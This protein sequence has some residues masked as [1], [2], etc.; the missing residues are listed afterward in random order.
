[1]AWRAGPWRSTHFFQMGRRRHAATI[2]PGHRRVGQGGRGKTR[3]WNDGRLPKE[4]EKAPHLNSLAAAGAPAGAVANMEE[5][6][7]LKEMELG[8]VRKHVCLMLRL[9]LADLKLIEDSFFWNASQFRNVPMVH[10]FGLVVRWFAEDEA[11]WHRL[12]SSEKNCRVM[13]YV[14]VLYVTMKQIMVHTGDPTPNDVLHTLGKF[15]MEM[16]TV[17]VNT[18]EMEFLMLKMH[19]QWILM[20]I[21]I[22]M[23]T[24]LATTLTK[25]MTE[26][27][28]LT[29]MKRDVVLTV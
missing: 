28:G 14:L 6:G 15:G 2:M 21:Q 8:K 18:M 27:H 13:V 5:W 1:M 7:C 17:Q 20:K 24:E 26:T 22:L 12:R 10:A 11:A 16:S 25:M 9:E 4:K 19:S 29:L 3:C 23:E